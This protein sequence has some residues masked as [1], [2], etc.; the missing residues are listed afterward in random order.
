MSKGDSGL[1]HGTKGDSFPNVLDSD[2]IKKR[3]IGFDLNEH[4]RKVKTLSKKQKKEIKEKIKNRTA[5]MKEYKQLKSDE[6]F[7]KRRKDGVKA[8]WKQEKQRIKNREK[9]TREW[10]DEQKKDILNNKTP[11]FGKRPLSG[12]HTFSVSKYPHLANKGEVIFP[13]TF[14]E[15]LYGW[16]GGNFKNSSPGKPINYSKKHNFRRKK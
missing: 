12:H 15:H 6:R 16:H 13:T 9:T 14:D 10:N 4:P 2:V 3:T 5:S 1:F 7:A 11:K 8:F